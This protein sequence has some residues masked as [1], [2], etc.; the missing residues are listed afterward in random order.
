MTVMRFDARAHLLAHYAEVRRRLM[1]SAPPPKA[2]PPPPSVPAI[3]EQAS[4]WPRPL[5]RLAADIPALST[6][7]A[8]ET[9]V[10]RNAGLLADLVDAPGRYVRVADVKRAICARWRISDV[11]LCSFRRTAAVVEPRQVGMALAKRLSLRSLPEIGRRFGWKDH[12]T[13]LHAVRKY[14]PLLDHIGAALPPDAG[15]EEWAEQAYE[16]LHPDEK[17]DA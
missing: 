3:P 7:V 5:F 12:T 6:A 9:V 17:C 11:D 8:M 15:P 13:V 1:G 10:A 14:A 4:D 2:L 16:V